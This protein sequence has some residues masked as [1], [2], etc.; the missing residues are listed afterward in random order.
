MQRRE[1][2]RNSLA[3]TALFALP[4]ALWSRSPAMCRGRVVTDDGA[5]G[6]AG[7]LVSN[8][9]DVTWSDA[10]GRFTLPAPTIVA[11]RAFVHLEVPSGYR[12]ATAWY[13]DV[14]GDEVVF[15]LRAVPAEAERDRL[16]VLHLTDV[17]IGVAESPHY[18]S[19]AEWAADLRAAVERESPDVIAITGDLTDLG[20][21]ED[22]R[23]FAA[24]L[25]DLAVPVLPLFAGH[26]G[27]VEYI[28]RASAEEPMCRHYENTMGPVQQS[29]RM[30][31]WR[32]VLYP[33]PF[34]FPTA[35]RRAMDRWFGRVVASVG[36]DESVV[37][38]AHD[39]T[40]WHP[41]E[42]PETYG[43]SV[44]DFPPGRPP[45]LILNGQYHGTRVFAHEGT[46][47]VGASSS[48]M[49]GIDASPR[50]YV[51]IDLAPG[52]PPVARVEAFRATAA[53]AGRAT[54]PALESRWKVRL[55]HGVHMAAPVVVNDTVLCVAAEFGGAAAGV[56][57]LEAATGRERWRLAT[58]E[59]VKHA[60]VVDASGEVGYV[61][62]VAGTAL[63]FNVSDGSIRW[64]RA[65]PNHPDRW[66][67]QRPVLMD[68]LLVLAQESARLA[69]RTNDGG[70][71]WRHGRQWENSW[72]LS[73]PE[74]VAVE[75]RW[76]AP[77]PDSFGG[78]RMVCGEGA[79]GEVKWQTALTT[80]AASY[81]RIYQLQSATPV[82]AGDLIIAPGLADRL[83]ALARRD[84]A[85]QWAE[86]V[87]RGIG[88]AACVRIRTYAA[89]AE[90]FTGMAVAADRVVV[91]TAHGRIAAAALADGRELWSHLV[92][93]AGL[94]DC[95]PYYRQGP[96]MLTPPLVVGDRMVFGGTDGW[97]RVHATTDGRELAA[98]NRGEPITVPPVA[99]GT[100]MIVT[101]FDGGMER[102]VGA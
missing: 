30:G 11:A 75:G 94:I 1:F 44:R 4:A 81:D 70:V 7:V 38:V 17:H 64:T 98:W 25:Q 102:V 66:L 82:V 57:A 22:L 83:V 71:E 85:L 96:A 32:F 21:P 52:R 63:A 59:H 41:A 89:A 87:G 53:A 8:G 24:T 33:E 49:G 36:D 73:R 19:P 74:A 16:R 65:L 39:P 40:V 43:P 90:Y 12:P 9:D 13:H 100:D 27:L 50:S 37:L 54:S 47:I 14:A 58:P 62:T 84:G 97:L 15:R 45:E 67:Y 28:E 23:A 92:G 72:Q 61:V 56:T 60:V 42:K 86:T 55:P 31:R 69:L 48:S 3:A 35:Q 46:L 2:L 78:F 10:E 29:W 93:E 99:C 88:P 51:V 18:V 26:D 68:G 80:P 6:V 77:T 76:L 101:T 34:G 91:T 95:V 5:H 20:R 79:T